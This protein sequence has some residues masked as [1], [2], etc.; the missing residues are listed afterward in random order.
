MAPAERVRNRTSLPIVPLL[1]V[2]A[3]IRP[4]CVVFG[5]GMC[6]TGGQW[7]GRLILM[8]LIPFLKCI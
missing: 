5:T 2:N 3:Y 8:R 1:L 7:P 4:A 6:I